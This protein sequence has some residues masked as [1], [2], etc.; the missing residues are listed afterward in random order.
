MKFL[1]VIIGAIGVIL[2]NSGSAFAATSGAFILVPSATQIPLGSNLTVTLHENSY[3]NR[4][5]VLQTKL[6][7]TTSTLKLTNVVYN[8]HAFNVQIAD[9][10]QGNSI[11]MIRGVDIYSGYTYFTGD[12]VVATIT[13]KTIAKGPVRVNFNCIYNPR[14]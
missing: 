2:L 3:A 10:H 11:F 7:Y 1:S 12:H 14:S 5:N 4:M 8:T 6:F 9:S 13:F